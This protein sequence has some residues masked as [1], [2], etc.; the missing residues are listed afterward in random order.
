[1]AV[2][3]SLGTP[4]SAATPEQKTSP[5]EREDTDNHAGGHTSHKTRIMKTLLRRNYKISM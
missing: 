1:M 3:G 5:D 2:A 4:A